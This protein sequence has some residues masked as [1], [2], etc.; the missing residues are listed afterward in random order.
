ML[1]DL[2]ILNGWGDCSR[3]P[4]FM[5]FGKVLVMLTLLRLSREPAQG[6]LVGCLHC[7]F[8]SAAF[9]SATAACRHELNTFQWKNREKKYLQQ[10]HLH[11]RPSQAEVRR[12]D[13]INSAE[14]CTFHYAF[15]YHSPTLEIFVE[16][17]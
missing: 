13:T 14:L 2:I 3:I 8:C 7:Y 9:S 17:L 15:L 6:V 11:T 1:Q 12:S 10:P 4:S 5:I 16:R